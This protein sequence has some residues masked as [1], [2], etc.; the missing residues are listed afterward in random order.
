[1]ELQ[2]H[3]VFKKLE[4]PRSPRN[5]RHAFMNLVGI[6]LFGALSGITS[7]DGLADFAELREAD[8]AGIIPM[9]FGPPCSETLRRFFNVLNVETFAECFREFTVTLLEKLSN[10]IPIDGKRIRNSGKNPIQIVSA[11]CEENHVVLGHV[12]VSNESNEITTIPSLLQL[13]DVCGKVITIDAIGCQKTITQNIID[14]DGDYV[15]AVKGNQGN[16]FEDIKAYFEDTKDMPTHTE[17]DKGHGRIEKR[18]CYTTDDIDW[19][20]NKHP[21]WAALTSVS[22]VISERTTKGKKS[23]EARYYISSLTADPKYIGNAVRSHW[24]IENKLHWRLD[25]IYNQDK[26]CVRND[27]AAQNLDT[28]HKWALNILSKF[29]TDKVSMKSLQRRACMSFDFLLQLI[30]KFFEK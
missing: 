14:R 5:Q 16:L 19:L 13:I 22:Q 20:R 12:K 9:P 10:I 17:Y 7:F 30:T 26:A 28:M 18:T 6:G 11:W 29:K 25:V 3:S 27:N 4:D 2:W 8:L 23:T 1:M 24:G 15:I 21:G